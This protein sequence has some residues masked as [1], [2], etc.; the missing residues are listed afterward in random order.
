MRGPSVVYIVACLGAW[1]VCHG[2]DAP[3]H[4]TASH[5]FRTFDVWD[6]MP[7]MQTYDMAMTPDGVL[8]MASFQGLRRFDGVALEPVRGVTAPGSRGMKAATVTIDHQGRLWT[9]GYGVVVLKEGESWRTF[10]LENGVPP[11]LVMDMEASPSGEIWLA[12]ASGI[13]RGREGR[14]EPV[15]PAPGM[16]AGELVLA[17][18]K[19]GRLWC[20]GRGGLWR[21]EGEAW[22]E[23]P[24]PFSMEGQAWCGMDA[25]RDGGI[26]VASTRGVWRLFAGAWERHLSRP[27]ATTGD[28]TRLLEDEDGGLWLGGLRTGLVFFDADG[29]VSMA[30]AGKGLTSNS[31]TS[32]LDDGCG[33]IWVAYDGGCLTRVR[34]L[35]IRTHGAEEGLTHGVKS[36]TEEE[37]GVLAVG[38]EGGGLMR[39]RDGAF[40]PHPM[41]GRELG[42]GSSIESV[43]RDRRGTLWVGTLD[44]GLLRSD[45]GGW[46]RISPADTGATLITALFEDRRGRMWVGTAAGVAVREGGRFVSL[47]GAKGGPH[48]V[49]RSFAEDGEGGIWVCGAGYGVFRW[50]GLRFSRV[51]V[52]GQQDPD[53]IASLTQGRDGSVWLGLRNSGVVWFKAGKAKF[54]GRE[55]GIVVGPSVTLLEDAEEHL[56]IWTEDHCHRIGSASFEAVAS[57][58]EARLQPRTFGRRDGFPGGC[59]QATIPWHGRGTGGVFGGRR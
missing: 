7:F 25:A 38:T 21:R 47:D 39:W 34:R 29:G 2:M 50:D 27:D 8:W 30:T 24:G 44:R 31:V 37:P 32:L 15:A 48:M 9:G 10:G 20:M 54:F 57:G 4:L 33:N 58:R 40:E 12:C 16:R 51:E 42:P 23:Q 46:E 35:S 17:V 41:A 28:F 59:Q 3:R 14:F 18:E 43:W 22:V 26:W 5:D 53:A 13:V 55:Q 56:W 36:V 1:I 52:P 45:D 11:A 49:A 19:D 6:G